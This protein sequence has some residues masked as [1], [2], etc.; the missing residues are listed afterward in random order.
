MRKKLCVWIIL[1]VLLCAVPVQAGSE[2]VVAIMDTEVSVEL[3]AGYDVLTRDLD[4]HEDVLAAYSIDRAKLLATLRSENRYMEAINRETRNEIMLSSEMTNNSISLWSYS[5]TQ[6]NAVLQ[7]VNSLQRRAEDGVSVS[8]YESPSGHKFYKYMHG[9][10][11]Y[12][13]IVYVTVENGREIQIAAYAYNGPYLTQQDIEALE[14]V[15][16]S[17]TVLEMFPARDAPREAGPWVVVLG[18]AIAAAAV[19]AV[20]LLIRWRR[21]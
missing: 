2:L 18:I 14:A 15:V 6:N 9:R 3:P 11:E 10:D 13:G 1:C 12:S 20:V 17:F 16:D 19:V 4:Q 8:F 5:Q 7:T 21:S